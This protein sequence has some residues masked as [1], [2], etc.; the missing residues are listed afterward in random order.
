MSPEG[1]TVQPKRRSSGLS[2]VQS[3]AQGHGSSTT[4]LKDD[5]ME[6]IFTGELKHLNVHAAGSGDP[7]VLA[8][9][10]L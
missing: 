9:A 1:M 2:E 4:T 5:S 8:C 6:R 3:D 7:P 10:E